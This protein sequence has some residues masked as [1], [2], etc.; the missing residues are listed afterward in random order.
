MVFYSKET[1]LKL[2]LEEA[3]KELLL[4]SNLCK[5]QIQVIAAQEIQ[6]KKLAEEL[7]SKSQTVLFAQAQLDLL[8]SKLFGKSSER[9]DGVDGLPLFDSQE[10]DT[11]TVTYNRKKRTKFGRTEQ[12]ELPKVEII[13]ELPESEV[14]EK[15]LEKIEGQ[16]EVSELVNIVPGRFQLEIHKR[17]KYRVPA[18]LGQ[19][20]LMEKTDT[21][22]ISESR[23]ATIVTAPGELKLK[24]GSRY[25]IDFG[26]EVGLSKFKYH[27]PLDRQSRM[28]KEFGLTI[29]SQVLYAQTDTIAWYLRNH[30]IPKFVEEIHSSRMNIADETYI[31]NLAKGDTKRF[32]LWS[33]KSPRCVLFEMYDSR[34]KAVA[35]EFLKDLQGVLLT[36]GY[37]VYKSLAN[38]RLI[39]ANDWCHPRR[40]F[41]AAEKTHPTESKFFVE[42]IRLLFEIEERLRENSELER[43]LARQ[44]ESRPIIDAIYSRCLDLKNVLPQLPIGKAIAYT[45]KL[46]KGLTVFLDHPEVPLDSNAIERLQRAPVLGRNNYR[47]FKTLETARIG[48]TWYSVIA[49]CEANGVNTRE[50]L[51]QTLRNILSQKPVTMPWDWSKRS[52]A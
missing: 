5:M 51:E 15:G 36:D 14:K 8:K 39:W 12:P 44:A 24:E 52:A 4:Y 48:A 40:K 26:V 49:T 19:G 46:W 9:R 3:Q 20:P 13:F 16:F 7:G 31:E 45:L 6:L 32:W 30:V 42:Q 21:D 23:E 27:L 1:A 34:T 17:Q 10:S 18:E 50:Y 29:G 38:E 35:K 43:Q 37:A 25:S 2:S 28:M 41:V 22:L 47:G 11:K 33:V